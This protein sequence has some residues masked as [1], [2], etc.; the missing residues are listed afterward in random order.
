MQ[1][2]IPLLTSQEISHAKEYVEK[3]RLSV[4]EIS[5]PSN[6]KTGAAGA[7]LAIA[8][9]HHHA[10]VRLIDDH[11]YASVASL[12]RV[13]FE[14]YVRGMWLYLCASDEIASSFIEGKEPPKLGDLLV[15]LEKIE[16]F[17]EGVLSKVKRESWPALCAYTHTGGLHVQRWITGNGIEPNY[18]RDEII[19]ALQFAEVIASFSVMGVAQ[20]ANDDDLAVKIFDIFDRRME[21]W[22]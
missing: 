21:E 22:G 15:E 4:H 8:Q 16:S 9:E 11:R 19:E 14:A 2:G 20:M 13:E 12:V 10:I 3:L 6:P 18:S 7:C 5:L 17:N 1:K